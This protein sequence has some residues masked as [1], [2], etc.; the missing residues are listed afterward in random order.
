MQC[1]EIPLVRRLLFGLLI[2]EGVRVNEALSLTWSDVD[3]DR[4]V[5]NLDTNKTDDPRSW[6]MG[7][8]VARALDAW[9]E[10]RGTKATKAPHIFP[11]ALIG[12]RWPLAKKLREG[13]VLAGV[14]R[15]EL[16]EEKPGRR[17]LR[18]HDLRG[19]FVTLA[20]AAGRTEAWVTD[21]TGHRSSAMIYTYK[22]AARTA[23]ELGLGWLA[24]LDEAIPELAPKT[25]QGA[26][27]VQTGGRR[28][29]QASGGRSK[30]SSKRHLATAQTAPGPV[31]NHVNPQG[32]PGFES[33]SLRCRAV[34]TS[35]IVRG[36]APS[37]R[38]RR[39]RPS[40]QTT[41]T[42]SPT[43][44]PG[45][46]PMVRSELLLGKPFSHQSVAIESLDTIHIRVWFHDVD[47]GTV[48]IEPAVDD[49]TYE[50]IERAKTT[51]RGPSKAAKTTPT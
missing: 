32:F 38:L 7:E 36:H 29:R 35:G 27:G 41:A 49:V 25:R 9:R 34:E 47:L 19:S 24:P 5:L 2:R 30:T 3:L 15:P 12:K 45:I 51:T 26:N 44:S 17:V 31:G 1:R 21:R 40:A 28:G 42:P 16:T 37:G 48:E 39:R 13:L 20:L 46:L 50:A 23:A 11:P 4:G 6:A 33:L 8:D 43:P 14:K 18:A 10:L 22:R